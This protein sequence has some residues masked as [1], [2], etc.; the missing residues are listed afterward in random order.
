MKG[1][2][3]YDSV[4]GNTR[5]IAEAVGAVLAQAGDVQ[6]LPVVQLPKEALTGLDLLVAGSPTQ[7]FGPIEGTKN[8]LKSLA[9]RQLNGVK[10]A[11]FDTR[12]DIK[13]VNSGFLTFMVNIFGY[14]AENID[15]GLKAKGGNPVAAPGGFFVKDKE[16]PLAD[17][18]LER[19]VAW[20]G[21][22]LQKL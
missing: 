8:F 13:S 21:E 10:V 19:A 3:V 16:G 9:P 4:Y 14:A 2:V 17:G 1:L 22:L 12:V 11:A 6:V 18:E 5:K 20:A 7:A 15:R